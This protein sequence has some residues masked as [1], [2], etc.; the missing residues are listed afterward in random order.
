MNKLRILLKFP[1]RDVFLTMKCIVAFLLI[2]MCNAFAAGYAQS[3]KITVKANDAT[4]KE[5]ISIIEKQSDYTFFYQNEDID[6]SLRFN[7]DL[8]NQD[9]KE[10]LDQLVTNTSLSY[11]ISGKYIFLEKT[12]KGNSVQQ[13]NKRTITGRVYD[14]KGELLIGVNVVEVGTTNGTVTDINGTYLISVTTPKP[15]LKFTY[16]GFKEKEVPVGGGNILDI[17]LEEDVS[18]LQEVVV[19]GHGTQKKVSV[20]GS[21]TTIKP[22]ELQ[23]GT[24]RSISNNLAGQLAGII[25]VQRSGEPGYD[26][27]QFWIRG[28]SS[29][30]GN[31]DPLILVDGIERSLNNIDPAEIESF[32]ILKDAAASAVYGVRGANGVIIITTKR[33]QIGKPSI[34]VRVEQAATALG[35]LP[36]FIG[37]TEYLSLLNEIAIDEGKPIRYP[38]EVIEKYRT[39]EDPDLY[40]NVNWIDA[41][42]DDFGY[43]T[44]A[45][46]TVSGGSDV[47]RYSLVTSYYGE[48]G[49]ITRDKRQEWDSSSRL[50]RYNVRSN[51]D[52]NI[53]PT[54]LF[55][56]D[57]GGYLQEGTRS[58]QS[59]DDLFGLA[60]DTPPFVHPPIYS[61]GEIPV[62]PERANP[63]ALATQ[64][65]YET[66]SHNQIESSASMEQDL[67]FLL[68]GL[69]ARILFSFD[70]YSGNGV[71]RSKSPDY[72][73]PA[74]GR[75][76]DG[77]LDLVIYRYGQS[78]L[79]HS[80]SAEWGNKST[81]LEGSLNYDQIFDE[82]HAIGL[83]FLYNQRSF[84]DGSAL[85]YRNQGIAA[86][87][88]YTFDNKY[89]GEFN[90]GY[91]GSE[92]FAKGHRF[93]FFP[94]LAVGW[95]LSEEA[96]ME[97]YRNTFSKIKLRASYGLVGNDQLGQNRGDYRFAYLTTIGDTGGYNWG[98]DNDYW[99]AG[100]WEGQVGVQNLTWEKVK[101]AN[102]GLE[103]GLWNSIELQVDGF[104]DHR[105]DIFM[106]R[107]TIPASAGF[108][109]TPFANYGKV[110]NRG[111]DISLTANKQVTRDFQF[112]MRGTFTYAK[113]EIT[114]Q[115][116]PL[117][118]IGTNRARTGH[119]IGQIFGL[120]D[121]GLFTDDD[122][123]TNESG[124]LELVSGIPKHTFAPVRPGDIKY[125]DINDDG[126]INS[127]DQCPI[128]GT[129]DPQIVYGFGASV[130]YKQIDFSFFFQGNG[131]TYR[132]IGGN[133]FIPGSGD[134]SM[135]NIY[136]N[137]QDRWTVDNPSQD[138]FWPRLS[139]YNHAN[140][141]QPSTW[142][143]K[144]MSMLRLKN[145]EIGYS[146]PKQTVLPNYIKSARIFLAGSNLLQFSKFKLWDPEIGF[147]N[148]LRYPIM[149]SA[150]IGFEIDF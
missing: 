20:V 67:K 23:I 66:F 84:E 44:R 18:E 107:R 56:V 98:V 78:F 88:S 75:K 39:G 71:Q 140:N 96:F 13:Q 27:S 6:H 76:D 79:G 43:N 89:V 57:I 104:K 143:L 122:F 37:S 12:A 109:Q 52:V 25:G 148:G 114:E 110:D 45:N 85:P 31:N 33:G 80:T 149:K 8:K 144:D 34:N 26:N 120:I 92:N 147:S 111:I 135:G 83:M 134:G 17:Q 65:G 16:I 48:K 30:A 14:T 113:N 40:P 11:R 105:Y 4:L 100:R 141:T 136:D 130:L 22:E 129:V 69:K 127:L 60:F 81:Y 61:S 54:T 103:L 64:L 36:T 35:K 28:I 101:K 145:I 99:R 10:I 137:Y 62:V 106:Q 19:V 5:V 132:I 97:P 47:L 3:E 150:S 93:G 53:T 91:N 72:Y 102:I 68:P 82:K 115:D 86:R 46:L 38:E 87:A 116:E 15:V 49:I 42:T 51:V 90:F 29:F 70:R 108:I 58:P 146:F 74:V 63:W 7:V 128:G 117:G 21:I 24:T 41:I 123:V 126:V 121:D 55:R 119:S 131:K 2:G 139:S 133:N 32:S 59:V 125:K 112:A 1:S 95:I 138:A 73:N 50:N 9:I 142:W 94:S 77:S 118:V 124:E